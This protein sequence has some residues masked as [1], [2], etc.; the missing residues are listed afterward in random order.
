MDN[1]PY[2]SKMINRIP[3]TSTRKA[4]IVNWLELNNILYDNLV[5]KIKLLLLCRQNK[6]KQ[7]Y[8]TDDAAACHGY[9]SAATSPYH[10]MF[11]PIEL[12]YAQIKGEVKIIN[13]NSDQ[14]IKRVEEITLEAINHKFSASHYYNVSG[15]SGKIHS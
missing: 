12:I 6:N 2:H 5:T 9:K 7:R 14:S 11:N 4:D 8:E 15:I 3:T 1:A 13:S 10:C